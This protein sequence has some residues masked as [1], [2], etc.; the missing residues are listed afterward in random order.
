MG[1]QGGRYGGAV[2]GGRG[3][4]WGGRGVGMGSR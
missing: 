1:G 4:V 3:Q 2:C